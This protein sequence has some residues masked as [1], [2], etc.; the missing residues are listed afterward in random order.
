[1]GTQHSALSTQSQSLPFWALLF[2]LSPLFPPLL[3]LLTLPDHI[4]RIINIRPL[5][6]FLPV[7]LL[8]KGIQRFLR[9]AIRVIRAATDISGDVSRATFWYRNEPLAAFGYQTAE[10]LVSEGRTEDVLRYV[11]SLEAGAAG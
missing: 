6:Q 7:E 9:E 2:L 11:M 8:I 5:V 4:L 3:L 10:T 1:M